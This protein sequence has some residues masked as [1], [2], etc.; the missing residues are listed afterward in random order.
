M[1]TTPNRKQPNEPSVDAQEAAI[2]EYV[3]RNP[4]P[5]GPTVAEL[6]DHIAAGLESADNFQRGILQ[7]FIETLDNYSDEWARTD[8]VTRSPLQGSNDP[9]W[10]EHVTSIARNF[11]VEQRPAVAALL[12]IRRDRETGEEAVKQTPE[13]IRTADAAKVPVRDIAA[14]L[15]ITTS[16]VYSVLRRP[17][18]K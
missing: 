2:V 14:L 16:Y 3:R 18:G 15:D 13:M 7:A 8:E 6:R 4:N 17:K 10:A 9:R 1:D 5:N 12:Q 11:P